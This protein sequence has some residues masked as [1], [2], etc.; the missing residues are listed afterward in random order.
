[1]VQ[2]F[3]EFSPGVYDFR[4]FDLFQI[5][6]SVT[7]QYVELCFNWTVLCNDAGNP[8]AIINI[9]AGA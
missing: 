2:L 1:M 9:T 4:V 3:S 6:Y 7:L 8:A 5:F